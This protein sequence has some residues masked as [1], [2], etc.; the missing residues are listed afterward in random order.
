MSNPVALRSARLSLAFSALGHLYSHL[1]A[2]IFFVVA[3]TLEGEFGLTHGEVIALIVVGNVLFGVVAPLAGWLGD[4]WSST[5]MMALFFVGTGGGMV[6]TGLASRPLEIALWLAVTGAFASIYHPVGIAWLVRNAAARG[7]AL[8]LNG[9]FGAIGPATAAVLAGTLTEVAG[10]RAAFVVPGAL[11]VATGVVFGALLA[12][13]RIVEI[14][15]DRHVDPPPS[16]GDTRRVVAVLAVSLLCTGLIYQ[17]TQPAL[18]K[19]FSERIGELT[20]D[21]VLGVSA[22]VAVVYLFAGA[23]QLVAGHLADRYPL[24]TVYFCC[25]V[26]QVPLLVLAGS[27]GGG[28]LMAVAMMMVAVNAGS[29]PAENSLVARYAP[30]HR[31]GLVF[32]LKFVLAFGVGGLG[33]KMEGLLYDLTGGFAW[34]FVILGVIAAVGVTAAWLLPSERREVVPAAAE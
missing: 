31:R 9:V 23:S 25:F 2:P 24:K 15:V 6:M 11:I 20:G 29:L 22:L 13:R 26:L 12:G 10:W 16:R 5:G 8:G 30:S 33:V 34:L 7:K 28:A 14:T 19:I 1:F 3:L 21:G 18:P 4:R 32:G 27:L 17:A